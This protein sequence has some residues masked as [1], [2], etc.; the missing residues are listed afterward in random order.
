MNR[1]LEGKSVR[2]P[3]NVRVHMVAARYGQTPA[4]VRDWPM[5]DFADAVNFLALTGGHG[6]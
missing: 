5:D 2:F 4:D 3:V 1:Y 6:R